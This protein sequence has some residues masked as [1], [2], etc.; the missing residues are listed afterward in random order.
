MQEGM[1]GTMMLVLEKSAVHRVKYSQATIRTFHYIGF[2][3]LKDFI[4]SV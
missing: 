1:M 4:D 2:D 3:I